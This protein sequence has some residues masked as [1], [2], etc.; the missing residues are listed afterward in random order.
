MIDPQVREWPGWNFKLPTRE[1]GPRP[2][3]RESIRLGSLSHEGQWTPEEHV[4]V[5]TKATQA[6]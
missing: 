1:I 6:W 5:L 3:T 4:E 2:R